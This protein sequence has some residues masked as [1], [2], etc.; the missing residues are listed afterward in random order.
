MKW[1]ISSDDLLPMLRPD[2]K[3]HPP[4]L[5]PSRGRALTALFDLTATMRYEKFIE[6]VVVRS[7]EEDEY[8]TTLCKQKDIDFFVMKECQDLSVHGWKS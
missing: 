4:I 5:I 3:Q 1:D 8:L 6:I 7:D 2:Y